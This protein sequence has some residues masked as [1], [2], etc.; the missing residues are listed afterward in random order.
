MSEY[1][2]ISSHSDCTIRQNKCLQYNNIFYILFLAIYM[3]I[4]SFWMSSLSGHAMGL[5]HEQSRPDRDEYV[6]IL[7]QNIIPGT[8]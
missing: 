6:D 2:P 1:S 5:W 8:K 3:I 7:F 4:S